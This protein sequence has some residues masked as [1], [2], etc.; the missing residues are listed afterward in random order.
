[1]RVSAFLGLVLGGHYRANDISTPRPLK[2]M[3]PPLRDMVIS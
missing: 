1:M 3:L 2:F